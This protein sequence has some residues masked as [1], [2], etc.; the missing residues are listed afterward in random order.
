MPATPP[1]KTTE[2]DSVTEVFTRNGVDYEVTVSAVNREVFNTDL[3]WIQIHHGR[4]FVVGKRASGDF[5]QKRRKLS[6]FVFPG[7]VQDSK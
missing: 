7:E 6:R 2:D 5:Y 1:P 4:P 3:Y